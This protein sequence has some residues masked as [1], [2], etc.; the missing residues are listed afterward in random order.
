MKDKEKWKDV[1]EEKN[2][3]IVKHF[4]LLM[5]EKRENRCILITSKKKGKERKVFF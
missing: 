4:C 5:C 1:K 3:G 2:K